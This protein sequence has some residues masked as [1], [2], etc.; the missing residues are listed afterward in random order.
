MTGESARQ[1][2]LD[3]NILI[4][5]R[6]VNVAE[7]PDE[8]AIS[9]VTLAELS[10]GPHQVRRND[11]QDLY[12]EHAER[13]R[14]MEIL[15]RVENE[16]DPIPFDAEAARVYGRLSAAIVAAGRKPRRRIADLMIAATAVAEG[17]PLFTTNPSDYTGLERGLRVVPVTRPPLP[18]EKEP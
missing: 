7:L 8:M 11:E 18:H 9:V 16:F 12:D 14:R 5:R 1:G 3:T 2:L 17:L 10:A 4:L 6:W 15:Q 13:A